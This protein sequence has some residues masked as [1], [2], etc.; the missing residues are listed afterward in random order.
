MNGSYPEKRFIIP[1]FITHQGCPHRCV[2]CNQEMTTDQAT[3]F[4]SGAQLQ[5]RIQSFLRTFRG[6]SERRE[7]AFYGGTFTGLALED[8]T[9]LLTVVQPF[10]ERRM[11]DGI[12]I[13]TRPDA[14]DAT[15]LD[16]LRRHGV[17]TI[18]VGAQSM[19][20]Q[21]LRN[22]RRGHTTEDV[23]QS[24]R[25]ARS[26]RF[27]VGIQIMLGLPGEDSDLFLTT[28][29]RVIDLRPDCVRIYP[30]LVLKGSPLASDYRRGRYEPL[31]LDKAVQWAKEALVLFETAQIKV[32]RMGLQPTPRLEADETIVAGPYH[33]AFRS[34]VRSALF[35]DR[36]C[37]ILEDR[38]N[39]NGHVVRFRVAPED[40]ADFKGHKKQNVRRLMESYGL[41]SIE[42]VSD[43]SLPRG[44]VVSDRFQGSLEFSQDGVEEARTRSQ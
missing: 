25:L 21:I 29:R 2:F 43:P 30:L 6:F 11:I 1:I 8:Q 24:V 32:I 20:D 13:S 41:T 3:G 22:T 17:H 27:E 4:P 44:R 42:I 10:M 38:K 39:R 37:R 28:V 33:P 34:L 40:V 26:M 12:R 23:V 36:A 31:S 16:F 35:Y 9:A 14:M 15:E 18:E 7:V 5:N 19:V